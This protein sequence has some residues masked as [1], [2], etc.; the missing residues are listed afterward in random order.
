MLISV[1]PCGIRGERRLQMHKHK[2]H[3]GT[4]G[5]PTADHPTWLDVEKFV[6][7]DVTSEDTGHL[8]EAALIEDAGA[9]WRAR[10]PGRQMIRLRFDKPK[11]LSRIRLVFDEDELERTQEFVLRWSQDGGVSY[12]EIVRK[13]YSFS[14]PDNARELEDYVVELDGLTILEL[15]IIPDMSGGGALASLSQLRLA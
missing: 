14:P 12:W 6:Q 8:I 7:V 11:K 10:Y 2:I 4:Q 13:Q 15:D 1:T 5:N 9:R 3:Q